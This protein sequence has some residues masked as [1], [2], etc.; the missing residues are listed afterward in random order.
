MHLQYAPH[1]MLRCINF[2][3]SSC[4]MHFDQ[5]LRHHLSYLRSKRSLRS[6]SIHNCNPFI[7]SCWKTLL[8]LAKGA[9]TITCAVLHGNFK[10]RVSSLVDPAWP[11]TRSA[12]ARL[13]TDLEWAYTRRARHTLVV[14]STSQ[15]RCH[16]QRALG[17]F[18]NHR[19]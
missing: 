3:P 10:A 8:L 2:M 15:A 9:V 16:R 5:L 13:L 4:H 17:S 11:G 12:R 18:G 7:R 19:A 1:T 14:Q 6:R